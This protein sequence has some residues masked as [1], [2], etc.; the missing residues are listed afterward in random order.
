MLR[1]LWLPPRYVF[2]CKTGGDRMLLF[3]RLFTARVLRQ[4]FHL[5][6]APADG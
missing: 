4:M 6:R 1:K 5:R 3:H 2:P